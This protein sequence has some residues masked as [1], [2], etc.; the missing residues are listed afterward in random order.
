MLKGIMEEAALK[1]ITNGL[2]K[3]DTNITKQWQK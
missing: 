3:S 2:L 1:I